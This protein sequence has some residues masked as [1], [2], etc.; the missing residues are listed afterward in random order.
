MSVEHVQISTI[1]LQFYLEM[2]HFVRNIHLV[3]KMHPVNRG[4]A[5]ELK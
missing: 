5:F 4:E 2:M 1:F 3:I